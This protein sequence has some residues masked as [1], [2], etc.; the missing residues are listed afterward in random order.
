VQAI[1]IDLGGTNVRAGLV[2][3]NGEILAIRK[4]PVRADVDGDAIADQ[5]AA[6]VGPLTAAAQ[7]PIAGI[8]MGIPGA[9][10]SAT[11]RI[12]PGLCNLIGLEDYPLDR[13]IQARCGLSCRITNDANLIALGE[14]GFGAARGI[15]NLLCLTIG[16]DVGGGL[17]LDGR[18]RGGPRGIAGEIGMWLERGRSLD[19]PDRATI[20]A[21]GGAGAFAREPFGS[22][23]RTFA[24]AERGSAQALGILEEAFHHLGSAIAKAHLLL[25]LEMALLCGGVS[26]AGEPLRA[27]VLR[28]FQACCYQPFHSGFRV[29]LGTL[30]DAAGILGAAQM[31]LANAG[32]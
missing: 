3:A 29:E 22:A 21:V 15:Q 31:W 17:I 26:Q 20:G 2:C 4:A 10:V 30:G 9:V 11:Q 25:D 12:L 23:E 8:G 5:I 24:E 27:G 16:T 32:N 19:D 7:E 14:H 6:L 1:G 28:A 13:A 18:L